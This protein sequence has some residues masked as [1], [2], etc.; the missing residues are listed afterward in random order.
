[1]QGVR[2]ICI[3]DKGKPLEIPQNKWVKQD[4]LYHI[5]HIFI[6]KQQNNI[7]GVELAEFDISECVPYN[8]YRLTRFAI[9]VEDLKKFVEMLKRCDDLNQFSDIDILELTKK[10]QTVE[11]PETA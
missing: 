8:C 1:M 11:I 2:C 4:E 5:T 3:D 6:M 7:Q 10:I 9:D